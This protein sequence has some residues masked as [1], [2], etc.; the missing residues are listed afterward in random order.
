M[1]REPEAAMP[2]AEESRALFCALNHQPGIAQALNVI[3][4]IARVNGDD[5]RAKRAYAVGT[6]L[7]GLPC[8]VTATSCRQNAYIM[9]RLLY[10]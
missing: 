9:Y 4:E 6:S 10:T 7:Y 8:T 2:L 1:M 3:G 5:D